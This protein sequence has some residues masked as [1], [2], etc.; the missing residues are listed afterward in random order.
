VKIPVGAAIRSSQIPGIASA[1][2]EVKDV[3]VNIA[4]T[5]TDFKMP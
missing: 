4:L 5:D 2:L 3:D 1:S